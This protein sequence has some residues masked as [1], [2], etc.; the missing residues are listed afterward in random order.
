VIGVV[1]GVAAS[2]EVVLLSYDP[3]GGEH[4]KDLLVGKIL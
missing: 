1:F 3:H 4:L 2:A